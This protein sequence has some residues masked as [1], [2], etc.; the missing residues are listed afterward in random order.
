[1]H[2]ENHSAFTKWTD[3]ESGVVSYLLTDRVA[4]YQR[5]W[6]FMEPGLRGGNPYL[7]F[8]ACHPPSKK[9]T[10]GAVSLTE[11]QEGI[12]EFPFTVGCRNPLLTE[13]GL[14][15]YVPI[16]DGIYEVGLRGP[17]RELFRLPRELL[18]GRHLYQLVTDLSL[19]CDGKTF[20]LDAEI[21]NAW[22]IA[23]VDRESAECT[24]L[25]W[26]GS[27]HHHTFFS[28]HDPTLFMVN[29]GHWTDRVTGQKFAMNNRIWVMDTKMTRYAP[30]LPDAWFGH[31][32]ET[33]HEWWTTKGTIAYCDYRHGVF[34]TDP[35]TRRTV[36]IWD[37]RCTHA[38]GED[39][40][41]YYVGDQGCYKW[42]ERSPCSVWFYNRESGR[43]IPIVSRMPSHP[44]P[45]RDFRTYHIDPHPA[46]S[47]DGR[48]ITYTTTAPGYLTVAMAPVADLATATA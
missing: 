5:A 26:F 32:S 39:S 35:D 8:Q 21:G 37:R 42:N 18:K 16:E 6:Y 1:M 24:P 25:Q 38:M 12:R 43:E 4:E 14:R 41:R 33:C 17:P 44:L 27:R 3:P 34:E 40:N 22:L 47:G 20:L 48:W 29:Q 19:S 9:W 13:D 28:R 2:L 45:W 11:D 46:F 31:N 23:T 30:L 36:K 15:A 10:L 7:W